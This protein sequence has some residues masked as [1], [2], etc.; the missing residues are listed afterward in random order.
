MYINRTAAS[1]LVIAN[2][3]GFYARNPFRSC[4]ISDQTSARGQQCEL[5]AHTRTHTPLNPAGT[6]GSKWNV[7]VHFVC[8]LLRSFLI[9]VF[10]FFSCVFFFILNNVT[11]SSA[12]VWPIDRGR[13][14]T[15]SF[16]VVFAFQSRLFSFFFFFLNENRESLW[17]ETSLYCVHAL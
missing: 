7:G 5:H 8:R 11:T 16:L 12:V 17:I 1:D 10:F 14:L 3:R 2:N 6:K 9:R 13:P 15:F 4:V